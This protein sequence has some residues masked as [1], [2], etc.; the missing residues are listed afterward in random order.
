[1]AYYTT[2]YGGRF[3]TYDEAVEAC[4]CDQDLNDFEEYFNYQVGYTKLL[5]WAIEQEN[6]FKDFNNEIDE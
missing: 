2:E 4:L 3:D 1:M 6:F 5:K